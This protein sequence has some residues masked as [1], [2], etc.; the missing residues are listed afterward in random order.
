MQS[1]NVFQSIPIKEGSTLATDTFVKITKPF[2]KPCI[3]VT[4]LNVSF[5]A[6]YF[7]SFRSVGYHLQ[8]FFFSVSQ[9]IILKGNPTQTLDC[10]Q[11]MKKNKKS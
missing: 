6:S 11:W 4:V 2:T 5:K 10:F 7:L 9:T 8:A 1:C 3:T